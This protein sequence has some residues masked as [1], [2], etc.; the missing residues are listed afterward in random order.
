VVSMSSTQYTARILRRGPQPLGM[1]IL[2]Q[3]SVRPLVGERVARGVPQHVRMDVEPE[4]RCFARPR[5]KSRR[6]RHRRPCP[7][8]A[9][10]KKRERAAGTK[11]GSGHGWSYCAS[12]PPS[13][14]PYALH[15]LRRW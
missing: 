5:P 9:S 10:G 3:P 15:G 14:R 7:M 8:K 6:L 1:I 13:K 12:V 4:L 11:S 2:D